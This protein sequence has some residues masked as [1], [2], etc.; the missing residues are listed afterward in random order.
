MLEDDAV[1][2]CDQYEPQQAHTSNHRTT[3]VRLLLCAYY[4]PHLLYIY[5]LLLLVCCYILIMRCFCIETNAINTTPFV[6]EDPHFDNNIV[7]NKWSVLP[8]GI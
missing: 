2:Y 5:N 4:R 1:L 7:H 8:L 6:C 3:R